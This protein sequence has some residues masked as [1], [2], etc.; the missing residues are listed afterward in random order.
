MKFFPFEIQTLVEIKVFEIHKWQKQSLSLN[1]KNSMKRIPSRPHDSL[2]PALTNFMTEPPKNCIYKHTHT[3][4]HI[5]Y[6]NIKI[7]KVKEKEKKNTIN[8]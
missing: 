4:T 5:Y 2:K 1:Q 7:K 6:I 3:Q 8:Y